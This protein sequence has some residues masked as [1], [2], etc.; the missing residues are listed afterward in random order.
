MKFIVNLGKKIKKNVCLSIIKNEC[1]NK[2]KM[3][4]YKFC[5]IL[6]KI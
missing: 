1:Y 6:L 5:L 2:F 4:D 3:L